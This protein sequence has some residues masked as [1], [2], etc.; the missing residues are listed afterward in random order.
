LFVPYH[1]PAV[2]CS[3]YFETNS[4][5]SNSS[6]RSRATILLLLGLTLD[7]PSSM[8]GEICSSFKNP[9]RSTSL[10]D[11]HEHRWPR[12]VRWGM[13]GDPP[14]LFEKQNE[15]LHPPQAPLAPSTAF[16]GPPPREAGEVASAR[17]RGHPP[18]DFRR[19][20]ANFGGGRGCEND[21]NYQDREVKR[22]GWAVYGLHAGERALRPHFG[23]RLA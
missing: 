5:D 22:N 7:N 21:F 2:S 6:L 10:S 9:V 3:E 23:L 20:N 4:A 19:F 12:P 17:W 15:Q 8:P 14:P 16:G 13:D 11:E 18:R 1:Q